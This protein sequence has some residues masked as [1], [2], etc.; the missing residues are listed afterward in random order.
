MKPLTVEYAVDN[1]MTYL[2]LVKYFNSEIS[3][4]EA[5]FIIWEKTCYPFSLE[6]VIVQLNELFKDRL[7]GTGL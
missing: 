1:K 4:E 2:G 5:D 3:D 6:Q 7:D